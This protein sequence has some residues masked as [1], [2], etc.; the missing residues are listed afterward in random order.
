LN[1]QKTSVKRS[2]LLNILFIFFP[3]MIIW[4]LFGHYGQKHPIIK[5][6]DFWIYIIPIFYI[7]FCFLITY[8]LYKINYVDLDQYTFAIPLAMVIS[9]MFI[10]SFFSFNIWII[11]AILMGTLLFSILSSNLIIYWIISRRK[12]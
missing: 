11:I 6:E 4:I 3:G 1:F 5:V 2:L 8:V 7:I 10:I 9:I 12:N